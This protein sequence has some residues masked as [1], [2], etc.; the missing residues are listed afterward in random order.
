MGVKREIGNRSMKG[1]RQICIRQIVMEVIAGL[2]SSRYEKGGS[3]GSIVSKL[4]VGG[5]KERCDEGIQI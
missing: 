1:Q 2:T 3:G 4:C 5:G